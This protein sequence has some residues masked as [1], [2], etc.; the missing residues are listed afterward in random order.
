MPDVFE[1]TM[2]NVSKRT[3]I[4]FICFIMCSFRIRFETVDGFPSSLP[5]SLLLYPNAQI[6][7]YYNN[8]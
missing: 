8:S 4:R 7:I 1:N 5:N 2:A 3:R 6:Y